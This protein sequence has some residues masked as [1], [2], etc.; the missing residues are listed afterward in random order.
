MCGSS[1]KPGIGRGYT[2]PMFRW[3]PLVPR[4]GLGGRVYLFTCM[5]GLEEKILSFVHYHFLNFAF[6]IYVLKSKL[7]LHVV[8]VADCQTL[9]FSAINSS[10]SGRLLADAVNSSPFSHSSHTA[11]MDHCVYWCSC[12]RGKGTAA[13]GSPLEAR[14]SCLRGV[15]SPGQSSPVT[16]FPFLSL[17]LFGRKA[18]WPQSRTLALS[19]WGRRGERGSQLVICH[20][21]YVALVIKMCCFESNVCFSPS[22]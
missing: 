8:P 18:H 21:V 22:A 16:C 2:G 5:V 7:F 10:F 9:C 20:H 13:E 14:A 19:W 4:I 1:D 11:F 12:V 15:G 3:C 6:K 17:Y